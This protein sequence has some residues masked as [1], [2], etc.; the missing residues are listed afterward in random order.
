MSDLQSRIPETG[1]KPFQLARCVGVWRLSSEDE[2]VDIRLGEQIASAVATHRDH[3]RRRVLPHI[4]HPQSREHRFD[5]V[6]GLSEERF[7]RLAGRKAFSQRLSCFL[8]KTPGRQSRICV[9]G[10]ERVKRGNGPFWQC[11]RR[12]RFHPASG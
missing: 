3:C 9:L 6:A 4:F 10:E 12:G 2:H 5:H 1:D 8:Q 11:F 7:N